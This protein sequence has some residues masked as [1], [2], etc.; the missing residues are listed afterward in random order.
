MPRRGC[1]TPSTPTPTGTRTSE[2]GVP[3]EP[4]AGFPRSRAPISTPPANAA[5]VGVHIDVTDRKL[6]ERKLARA[7]RFFEL[8][9]D[10]ICAIGVDGFFKQ[11]NDR[12]EPTLGWKAEELRA[13]PFAEF[14]HPD[15]LRGTAEEVERLGAE[16]GNVQFLNRYRTKE[17]GWRWLEW[18]STGVR[19]EGLIYASARDVT[20]R[21]AAEEAILQAEAESGHSPRRGA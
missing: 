3:M 10:M 16:R 21:V 7:A 12:W 17:G 14:V 5:V 6:T 1:T 11:L 8:S 15:D 18:N 20:S 2:S 19:E 9:S 4:N 13:R